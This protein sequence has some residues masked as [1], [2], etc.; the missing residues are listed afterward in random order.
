MTDAPREYDKEYT[1]P[2]RGPVRQR[3]GV[4][5]DRGDVTRFVVQLEYLIEP[6]PGGWA[7]VVRYDPCVLV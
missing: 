2:I 7:T 4:D 5:I 6:Y 1:A 3:V